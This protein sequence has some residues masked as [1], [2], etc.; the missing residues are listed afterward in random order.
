MDIAS[1]FSAARLQLTIH[2]GEVHLLMKRHMNKALPLSTLLHLLSNPR[3][4]D[5]V[6]VKQFEGVL[7]YNKEH[8]RAEIVLCHYLLPHF[9]ETVADHAQKIYW[10]QIWAGDLLSRGPE[11]LA[12][13]RDAFWEKRVLSAGEHMEE[14]FRHALNAFWHSL[15]ATLPT[16]RKRNLALA[17]KK[18]GVHITS[19]LKDAIGNG[20]F[21][22]NKNAITRVM[23]RDKSE[24]AALSCP[25]KTHIPLPKMS[26]KIESR[27]LHGSQWGM[28]CSAESPDTD[29]IGLTKNLTVLSEI[30]RQGNTVAWYDFILPL[31]RHKQL[32]GGPRLFLNACIVGVLVG[33]V[34]DAMDR[35]GRFRLHDLATHS[36]HT[37]VVL[38]SGDVWVDTSPGRYIRPVF[39]LPIR[40]EAHTQTYAELIL[41]EQIEYVD[42]AMRDIEVAVDESYITERTHHMEIHPTGIM[43]YSSGRIPYANHDCAPRIT[44]QSEMGHQ[45]LGV[46]AL[47][48]RWDT[49]FHRLEYGQKPLST[50]KIERFINPLPSSTNAVVMVFPEP[51]A[52]ED[53][54]GMN[55]ASLERGM[56][57]TT[58][59]KTYRETAQAPMQFAKVH[60]DDYL[61]LVSLAWVSRALPELTPN[62]KDDDGCV[63]EGTRV[64]SGDVLF[65]RTAPH[66]LHGI[67]T[68]YRS[69]ESGVVDK[70]KKTTN[71]KRQVVFE[72]Q[73]RHFRQP[74]LGDKFASRH[75][76]QRHLDCRVTNRHF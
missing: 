33:T 47:R 17:V 34:A 40:P 36:H 2:Q 26:K 57:R 18:C 51:L 48:R 45:A 10:L 21:G 37:T 7:T 58:A 63:P 25:R 5:L 32:T 43:G 16:Q 74:Q 9:G 46:T 35:L 66:A 69:K 8:S 23:E 39:R 31:V 24:S 53:S 61:K 73:V 49:T 15:E 70:V 52:Q 41:T 12:T 59:Y 67:P 4:P 72:V 11:S 27:S 13:D 62:L 44:F 54:I 28:V 75:G 42:A 14:I 65:C 20:N 30:T 19:K 1:E 71:E 55:R 38:K 60:G 6:L 56:F 29:N 50:T 64:F 3:T 76:K 22:H 68:L